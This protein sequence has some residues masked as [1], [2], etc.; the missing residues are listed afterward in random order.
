M[1]KNKATFFQACIR[2][3]KINIIRPFASFIYI[4]FVIMISNLTLFVLHVRESI[5]CGESN[6]LTFPLISIRLLSCHFWS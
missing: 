4:V 5:I 3:C 6:L 1:L 2:A